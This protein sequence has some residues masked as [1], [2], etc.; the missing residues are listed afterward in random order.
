MQYGPKMESILDSVISEVDEI[1]LEDA[2]PEDQCSEI[3]DSAVPI[4]TREVYDI[5]P[6]LAG[7]SISDPGLYGEDSDIERMAQV[8]IYDIASNVAHQ[9]L[10]ERREQ[11]ECEECGE[12]IKPRQRIAAGHTTCEECELLA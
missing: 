4:Y 8:Q 11:E 9:R 7:Y 1:D 3:A 2:Y 12:L 5:I 6:E 10:H